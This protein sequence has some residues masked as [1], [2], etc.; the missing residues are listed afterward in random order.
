[1]PVEIEQGEAVQ[2]IVELQCNPT[3]LEPKVRQLNH[4]LSQAFLTLSLTNLE[5]GKQ[6]AIQPYDPTGGRDAFDFGKATAPFDG[7]PLLAIPVSFPL[8]KLRDVLSPGAYDC[9]IKYS[10]PPNRTR[11]WRG[12][13]AA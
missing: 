6:F 2:A 9:E 5:N 10:I 1:M 12:G 11:W 8:L 3:A 13:D 4:F 7:T